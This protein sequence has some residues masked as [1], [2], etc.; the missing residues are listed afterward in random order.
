MKFAVVE[1]SSKSG[2]IW[3]HT[4]DAPNYLQDPAKVID[5]TSFGSYVSALSGEHIPLTKFVGADKLLNK[6]YKRITGSWP[7]NYSVEHFG[8]FDVLLIV[9]QISDAHEIAR[10]VARIKRQYPQIFII[11]VPTQPFGILKPHLEADATA[12][13]NF[14]NYMNACDVFLTVVKTTKGWYESM[15]NTPVVYLPQIYPTHFAAQH[16]LPK[17]E[18]EKSI[19]VAGITDR[20]NI[21]QGN[22]GCQSS[23]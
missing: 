12:K 8:Q 9:H 11:G 6:V 16:F 18:K 22:S 7:G 19:F 1:Y 2:G 10:F 21:S 14:I 4:P 20:P 17:Q 13:Q 15:S 23:A 5:A 3:R